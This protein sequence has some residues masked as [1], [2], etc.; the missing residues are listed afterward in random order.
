MRLL[1]A[2][3]TTVD[4]LRADAYVESLLA[5]A[6]RRAPAVPVDLDLDPD[7]AATARVLQGSLARIHPS[8]RFEERL[9]RR[10]ADAARTMRRD[11]A[12]GPLVDGKD[13]GDE[14]P[15][16]SIL[17]FPRLPWSGVAPGAPEG[18]PARWPI[19]TP[20]VRLEAAPTI[21]GAALTSAAL[22]LG[23]AAIV[24]WRR[25]RLRRGIA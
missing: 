6:E 15:G 11:A 10:L 7:V 24:A 22:S 18:V 2:E 20:A 14:D 12:A 23:A 16:P 13:A 19:A 3:T 21:A 17:A 8:F 25:G 9:S 4:A 5:S 1:V